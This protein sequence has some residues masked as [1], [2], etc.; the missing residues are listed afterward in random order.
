MVEYCWLCERKDYK[1]HPTIPN[2]MSGPKRNKGDKMVVC[3]KHRHWNNSCEKCGTYTSKSMEY[4]CKYC[5]G[6]VNSRSRK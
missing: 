5:L 4:C 2:V 3:V 6:P 1:P